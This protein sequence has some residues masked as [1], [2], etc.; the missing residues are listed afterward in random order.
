MLEKAYIIVKEPLGAIPVT[1]QEE[2]K[3]SWG[4]NFS[5]RELLSN[6]EWSVGGNMDDKGHSDEVSDRNEENVIGNQEVVILV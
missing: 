4:E 3:E 6:P 2:K 1:A 5:L